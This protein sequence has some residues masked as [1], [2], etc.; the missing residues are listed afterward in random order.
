MKKMGYLFMLIVFLFSGCVVKNNVAYFDKTIIQENDITITFSNFE[1]KIDNKYFG[2]NMELLSSNPKQ[3]KISIKDY[4]IY[5]ESDK[6]E[7]TASSTYKMKEVEEITLSCDIT[8]KISFSCQLPTSPSQDRYY[9]E[10]KLNNNKYRFNF[11]ERKDDDKEEYYVKYIVDGEEVFKSK[12]LTFNIVEEIEWI[13]EDYVYYCNEW[14]LDEECKTKL[15]D[16]TRIKE[17][18]CLYGNKED[19]IYFYSNSKDGYTASSIKYIPKSKKLLIPKEYN[20]KKVNMLGSGLFPS[21]GDL[22][23]DELYISLNITSIY[24]YNTFKGVKSIYFEGSSSTWS[25]IYQG[26]LDAGTTIHFNQGYNY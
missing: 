12:L 10:V 22:D 19:I 16:N 13:S 3:Q 20:R 14:Y 8:E 11:Y 6:A 7:Y 21:Y 15:T 25:E 2:F 23:V 18:M 17:D 9:F 5:R 26:K 1:N 24:Q 4:M